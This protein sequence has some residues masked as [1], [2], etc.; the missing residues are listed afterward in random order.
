[1]FYFENMERRTFGHWFGREFIT[2]LRSNLV[3]DPK[4]NAS[5]L[6]VPKYPMVESLKVVR[7]RHDQLL[8]REKRKREP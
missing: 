8:G 5:A 4:A 1:M 2:R 3:L 6:F 7:C